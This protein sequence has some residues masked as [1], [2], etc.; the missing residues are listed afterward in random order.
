[1]NNFHFYVSLCLVVLSWNTGR[2]L[3]A[4]PTAAPPVI[5]VMVS[6]NHYDADTLLPPLMEKLAKTNGWK[7]IV[8]HGHGTGNFANIDELEQAD[9]LVI[10]IRRLTLPQDQMQKL[11]AFVAAGKGIVALRTA[12]HGFSLNGKPVPAGH[13][14]WA[15]FDSEVLGGNY[16]NHGKNEVGSD[17]KN[18]IAL[19]DSPIL[20]GVQPSQ[21][22]SEGSLYF[23]APVKEDA[24]IYQY[25]S[26]SERPDVPL[27]WIRKHGKSRVAYTALGHQT[28]LKTEA[29]PN[30]LRNL[31]LWSLSE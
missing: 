20:K 30:L 3:F 2:T 21:W 27:T 14:E 29:F 8:L 4:E 7:I 28:D 10:Y 9:V 11:Q 24:V 17:V 26:S 15:S 31:L 13:A 6:D 25:A 16:N 1:M 19:A 23:T 12:S 5:A 22:H 18:V